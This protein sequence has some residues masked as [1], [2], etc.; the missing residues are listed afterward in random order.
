MME[1]I[2]AEEQSQ[3]IRQFVGEKNSVR[4]SAAIVQ[5]MQNYSSTQP[6]HL[7]KLWS[8]LNIAFVERWIGLLLGSEFEI[9]QIG[10][11]YSSELWIKHESGGGLN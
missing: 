2:E 3:M 10:D 5:W 8:E 6:V 9:E 11:F 4:W 7:L 1:Q